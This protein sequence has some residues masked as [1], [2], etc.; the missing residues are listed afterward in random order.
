MVRSRVQLK[1]DISEDGGGRKFAEA[2]ALYNLLGGR[3]KLG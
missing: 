2:E 1:D 3:G